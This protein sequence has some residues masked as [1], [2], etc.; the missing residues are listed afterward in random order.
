MDLCK[1]QPPIPC[2]EISSTLRRL[3]A[4]RAQ[5]LSECTM[6]ADAFRSTCTA[7]MAS[8]CAGVS[9]LV[10]AQQS[11][12][13]HPMS[14]GEALDVACLPEVD[15]STLDTN[16]IALPACGRVL[17]VSLAQLLTVR[18]PMRRT[19]SNSASGLGV[20]MKLTYEVL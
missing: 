13:H 10:L 9:C 14:T 1:Q 19:A 5:R 18:W 20:C 16:T 11:A 12:P 4:S 3:V 7:T 6:R 2:C 17:G 8:K 15:L